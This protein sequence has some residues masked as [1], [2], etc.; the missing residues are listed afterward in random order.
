MQVVVFHVQIGNGM[1]IVREHPELSLP[2]SPTAIYY[3]I[4]ADYTS[5]VGI[6]REFTTEQEAERVALVNCQEYATTHNIMADVRLYR[7]D[8]LKLN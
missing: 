5:Q 2:I 3:I 7:L 1:A 4:S 8:D 6:S